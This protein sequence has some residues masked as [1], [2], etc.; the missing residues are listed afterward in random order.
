[1]R[2]MLVTE[3]P[4]PAQLLEQALHQAGHVLIATF[5]HT[6]RLLLNIAKLRP[7]C[8]V[9]EMTVPDVTTLEHLQRIKQNHPCPVVMFVQYQGTETISAA[10]QA[11]VS[12]YIVDGLS[13]ERVNP[14][15]E[16]ALSRFNDAKAMQMEFERV[17]TT[18]QE[19][20]DIERAKGILMRR[21]KIPENSAYQT[22]CTMAVNRNK[23][24]AEVA[25]NIISA[26]EFISYRYG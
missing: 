8:I 22:L 11:G 7:D 2:I 14:I 6:R 1:M 17:H 21:A 10:V 12:A 19:R 24:I 20:K 18:L 3:N 4:G 23:R 5:A 26:E 13:A 9:L 16:I 15:L 25:D